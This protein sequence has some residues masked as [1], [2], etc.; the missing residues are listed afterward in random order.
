MAKL[1]PHEGFAGER[2][3]WRAAEGG[4][5]GEVLGSELTAFAKERQRDR[6]VN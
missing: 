2:A 6:A 1:Q 4:G 3:G 5:L